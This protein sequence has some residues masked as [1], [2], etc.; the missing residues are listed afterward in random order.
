MIRPTFAGYAAALTLLISST[1]SAATLYVSNVEGHPGNNGLSPNYESE[2]VGPISSIHLALRRAHATDTIHVINTGL[3]YYES[4]SV[5]GA[6]NSGYPSAN[7]VIEGNGAVVSGAQLVPRR[8]FRTVRPEVFRLSPHRKGYYQLL[9]N[10][11]LVPEATGITD[12]NGLDNLER[13]QWTAFKGQMYYR[14]MARELIEEQNYGIAKETVGLTLY[15]VRN[16]VIRNLH[17]QHFQLDGVNA[18]DLVRSVTLENVSSRQNARSGVSVNGSSRLKIVDS[19]VSGNRIDAI[20]VSER[21]TLE[22]EDCEV[23]APV[24]VI[25]K[26]ESVG[27]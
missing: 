25:E 6:D 19:I 23:D 8:A 17:F 24:N 11:V 7:F 21:G 26:G 2:T 22:L 16:V 13:G 1:C 18:H 27:G 9:R 5:V 14:S 20:R 15:N 10:G 12:L 3:P 4:I